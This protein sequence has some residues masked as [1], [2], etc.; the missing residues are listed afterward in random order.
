MFGIIDGGQSFGTMVGIFEMRKV[1]GVGGSVFHLFS[2]DL[3][4]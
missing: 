4:Q 3:I 1:W 2:V